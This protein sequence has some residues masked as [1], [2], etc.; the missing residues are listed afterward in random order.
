MGPAV[1][2]AGLLWTGLG[3]R[4]ARVGLVVL[5]VALL[6]E[7]ATVTQ[8]FATAIALGW[9]A[10]AL[11]GGWRLPG[12]VARLAV[13]VVAVQLALH[14]YRGSGYLFAAEANTGAGLLPSDVV[15]V[16]DA[17]G[18]HY[19]LWGVGVGA[20]DVA[21]LGVGLVGFFFGDR[22]QGWFRR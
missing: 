9:G 15:N 3:P 19:L 8:G 20:L 11:S 22:V 14:V 4:L 16:A 10:L 6:I 18:G 7:A 13:L 17:L 5:G 21:L 2:S 1:A 12:E